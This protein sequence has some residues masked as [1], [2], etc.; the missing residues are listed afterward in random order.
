M[1]GNSGQC[2]NLKL[3]FC[4]QRTEGLTRVFTLFG[5]VFSKSEVLF[6][7]TLCVVY[8]SA[9]FALSICAAGLSVPHPIIVNSVANYI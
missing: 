9:V 1:G 6:M 4:F 7:G 3:D 2:L 8:R 5:C